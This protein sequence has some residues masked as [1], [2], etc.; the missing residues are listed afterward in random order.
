VASYSQDVSVSWGGTPFTEV[1][2][3]DWQYAGGPPKGR[4]VVWTD[5]AGSVTVTTL[6]N[7]NT[8]GSE[9]GLRKELVISG[10]GQG[11][12]SYAVWESLSV[13]NEVNG[14]TRFTVT[15]KLLD[16]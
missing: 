12:T 4:G 1:V 7:A 5:E 8:S 10:G 11:L 13:A 2:G 3:L 15:F 9:Y 14:V 16:N 6:G